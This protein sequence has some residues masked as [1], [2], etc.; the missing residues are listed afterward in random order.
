MA[1]DITGVT[2]DPLR[3]LMPNRLHVQLR[4]LMFDRLHIQLHVLMP[5]RLRVQLR[6]LMFDLLHVQLRV[7]MFDRLHVQLRVLTFDQHHVLKPRKF[8]DG[9][10]N[11]I[12]SRGR[13]NPII[14]LTPTPNPIGKIHR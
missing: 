14:I 13:T 1:V 9:R 12:T 3:V 5:N 4:A 6:A 7:L 2:L 11:N 10:T 8:A